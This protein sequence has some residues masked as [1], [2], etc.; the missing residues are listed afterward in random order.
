MC[1]VPDGYGS[2]S[3]WYQWCTSRSSGGGFGVE[4]ARSSFQT[5]CHFAS[6]AW[7]SYLSMATKKPLVREAVGSSPRPRAAFRFLRYERSSFLI[8]AAI[9][10]PH[11]CGSHLGA[12]PRDAVRFGAFER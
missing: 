11:R 9:V 12:P 6:I 2:I 1:S 10:A 4:N 3:S 5:R 7:G 8:A